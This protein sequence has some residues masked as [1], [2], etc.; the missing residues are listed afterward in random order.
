VQSQVDVVDV[1]RPG[2]ELPVIAEQVVQ[3]KKQSGRPFVFWAQ[4]GLENEEV[5]EYSLTT[6]S[7]T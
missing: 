2:D 1:F 7:A 6:E 3:M 5:R 4:L